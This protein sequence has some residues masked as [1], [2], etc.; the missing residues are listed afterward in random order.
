METNVTYPGAGILAPPPREPASSR[1]W[2][3]HSTPPGNL[4][5][6]GALLVLASLVIGLSF[7]MTALKSLGLWVSIPCLFNKITGLPCLTCG[8]TRSFSL[9]AHGQFMAALRMH[10]LGPPLFAL[11]CGLAAYMAVSLASGYRIR[12]Q[13]S[14]GARRFIFIFALWIFVACWVVKVAFMK[15][16][17]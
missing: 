9:T 1:L 8:L 15:G 16:A 13:L 17:W 3:E 4:R 2:V 10:L 14:P 11:T 7:A 6:E 5:R 12:F